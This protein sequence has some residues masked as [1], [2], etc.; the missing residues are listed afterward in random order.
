MKA[1]VKN[2]TYTTVKL[3]KNREETDVRNTTLGEIKN[4]LK[5]MKNNKTSSQGM[6]PVKQIHPITKT[7]EIIC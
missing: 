4:P 3:G 5:K 6:L 2:E 7:L 1:N